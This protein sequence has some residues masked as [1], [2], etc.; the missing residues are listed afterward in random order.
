MSPAISPPLFLPVPFAR[1]QYF[2]RKAP[3]AWL[4]DIANGL[5]AF[6]PVRETA[7]FS[8]VLNSFA[9]LLIKIGDPLRSSA[10]CRRHCTHFL[11]GFGTLAVQPAINLGR[12]D[13][14]GRRFAA[15]APHFF[16]G[17][18]I[19]D[20][21]AIPVLDGKVRITEA[22]LAEV[23]RTVRAVEGAQLLFNQ[24]GYE[25]AMRHLAT[26][27]PASGTAVTEMR[28]WFAHRQKDR[29]AL[30]DQIARLREQTGDLAKLAFY[31]GLERHLAG[32]SDA[33]F[34]SWCVLLE[35]LRASA[36][37][38]D[39]VASLLHA[40]CAL[41]RLL[42]DCGRTALPDQPDTRAA[43]AWLGDIEL[44]AFYERRDP[45]GLYRLGE[46]ERRHLDHCLELADRSLALLAPCPSRRRSMPMDSSLEA[47]AF[48][49]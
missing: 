46:A 14:R 3:G 26:Q 21:G 41:V 11:P 38:H 8:A 7:A 33:L 20:G 28:I 39:E 31:T 17:V 27:P 22:G 48:G 34:L 43:A 37:Q 45:V 16:L 2:V 44:S 49:R 23:C 24:Q 18:T 12:I 29:A 4:A 32:D 36:G 42:E 19:R 25:A 35:V 13:L 10:L 40:M 47:A 15:A 1:S 30:D 6:D 9:L 5:D